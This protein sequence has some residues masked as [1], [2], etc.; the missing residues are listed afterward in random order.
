[1]NEWKVMND[2]THAAFTR[3]ALAG[4]PRRIN[5]VRYPTIAVSDRYA[6]RLRERETRL[7]PAR[8]EDCRQPRLRR[9]SPV[10]SAHQEDRR[11]QS[12]PPYTDSLYSR[13]AGSQLLRQLRASRLRV[14][15]AHSATYLRR[16]PRVGQVRP[17]SRSTASTPLVAWLNE[18]PIL[19]SVAPHRQFLQSHQATRGLRRGT[20]RRNS[21][22]RRQDRVPTQGPPTHALEH[23]TPRA[24]H[25]PPSAHRDARLRPKPLP[26]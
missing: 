16:G 23:P 24:E 12:Q 19:E 25:H 14:E 2:S 17:E 13:R 26:K 3:E 11:A 20:Q 7:L 8:V 4:H 18:T 22:P 15:A 9:S 1:M 21:L 6:W 5:S 10:F